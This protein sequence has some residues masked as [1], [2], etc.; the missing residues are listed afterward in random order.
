MTYKYFF[1]CSQQIEEDSLRRGNRTYGH[2]LECVYLFVKK[3]ARQ[4]KEGKNISKIIFLR[5]QEENIVDLL[6]NLDDFF[7]LKNLFAGIL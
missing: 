5:S 6:W 7:D 4:F 2:T 3:Q 1:I